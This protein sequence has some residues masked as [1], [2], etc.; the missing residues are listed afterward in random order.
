MNKATWFVIILAVVIVVLLAVLAWPMPKKP[1]SN[2]NNGAETTAGIEVTMPKVDDWVSSPLQVEGTVNGNG[3]AG[4][5]G[6]VGTVK[7][8]DESGKQLAIG[9]LTATTDWTKLPTS[10]ETTLKFSVGTSEKGQLIFDNE[11][12]SGN[13]ATAKE[14]ALPVRFALG[15]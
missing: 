13:P 1:E 5:E 14:F 11:N 8:M 12:P 4:F 15:K 3:W 2:V 10:F 6:Q 7:L 9:V